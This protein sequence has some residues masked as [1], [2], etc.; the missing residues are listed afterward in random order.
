MV[1]ELGSK[2][3]PKPSYGQ[4]IVHGSPV[5]QFTI[6]RETERFVRN[7][8]CFRIR[9]VLHHAVSQDNGFAG[10]EGQGL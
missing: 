10:K 9:S 7:V 5:L 8:Q 6:F 4:K 1:K 3:F 2:K